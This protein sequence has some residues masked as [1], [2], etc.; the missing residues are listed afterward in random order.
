MKRDSQGFTCF[1]G[2]FNNRRVPDCASI[3]D[4]F[5]EK[6]EDGIKA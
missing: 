1:V 5:E 2:I 4:T 3:S 6:S